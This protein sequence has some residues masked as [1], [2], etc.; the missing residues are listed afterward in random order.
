MVIG[1]VDAP[2][3]TRSVGRAMPARDAVDV[4][5]GALEF[6]T[7]KTLPDMVHGKIVRVD[8]PHGRLVG[9]DTTAARAMPGVVAVLTASDVPR[10][11]QGVVVPDR[12]VLIDGRIRQLGDPVAL[13]AAETLAEAE[14]AAAAVSVELEPLPAVSDPQLALDPESPRL[15]QGGNLLMELHHERGD[16]ETALA[17]AAV[18]VDEVFHTQAQ[19]H[20]C[21]EPGGGVG[22]YTNGLFTIW[23]GTQYPGGTQQDVSWALGVE[24]DDVR[25]I[26]TPMGGAFGAKVDGPV[27]IFL[28]LLAKATERPV[29][30]VLTRE[31]V[32]N[33]GTKRHPFRVHTRLGLDAEGGIV[34]VA[35]DALVDAGPYA[36][37]S[38]AVLKVSGETSTGPYR[39]ETA[40]FRGRAVYTNNGNG[41]GFRGYGVPQVAFAIETA[42]LE[43]ARRLGLDAVE[44]KRRNMLRPGDPHGL[45]GHI[46]GP[47]FRATEALD[48]IVGHPWWRDREEWKQQASGPWLRGTGIG[49]A[50]KGCGYGSGRGDHAG[51]RLA[52]GTDGSITIWA[53]PNHS[54]TGVDAAYAQVAADTLGRPY[55]DIDIRVGDTELVPESGSSAASRSLYVGGS[56]VMTACRELMARIDEL[57]LEAPIDWAEAGRRLAEAGRALVEATFVAPDVEDLGPLSAADVERYSPHRVYGS[58]VQVARIE[59]NRYTGEIAVRGVACAVDC[60]VAVNPAGVIGQTEGGII[61]GLGWAL[62]EDFKYEDGVPQTKSLETYLIPT[63]GDIPELDTILVESEEESGPFGAKGIAEVVLVPTAP[64]IVAAIHDATGVTVD[65]LPASP[66]AVYRLMRESAA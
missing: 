36:S 35:T 44:V 27:A 31:E 19:E 13:V 30:I 40:S 39:T 46:V 2:T 61:Q 20:V 26:S 5:T 3:L 34:A 9:L 54:G 24:P 62:M 38:P 8:I 45:Y 28:A 64:A 37:F 6:L 41:G 14:A 59:I 65:R 22:V 16:V 1:D 48:A 66:E 53:G 63:A 50:L 15:H 33:T 23:I 52:I 12:P 7:D 32:M 47:S 42:I 43:G 55:E 57:G 4:A 10:N 17:N 60:G 49:A 56:A 29:R 11:I 21:L 25:I 51:A 18:V 58:A